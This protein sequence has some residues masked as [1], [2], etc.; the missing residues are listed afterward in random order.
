M[1]NYS[2]VDSAVHFRK[3]KVRISAVLMIAIKTL[4][5]FWKITT[6]TTI[7]ATQIILSYFPP[8]M[9]DMKTQH[10]R[11]PTHIS[12]VPTVLHYVFSFHEVRWAGIWPALKAWSDPPTHVGRAQ[13]SLIM[14]Q[15]Q[16]LFFRPRCY[17]PRLPEEINEAWRQ[18]F[19][20][21]D[22]QHGL[23]FKVRCLESDLV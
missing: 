7:T 8:K 3:F 1:A 20:A 14:W 9:L 17:R 2:L 4:Q 16:R 21:G 12:Y 23:G 11:P 22:V 13:V 19:T 5:A 15:E 18:A 6:D 10:H